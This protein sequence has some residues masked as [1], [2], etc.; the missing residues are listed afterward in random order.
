MILYFLGIM[1]GTFSFSQTVVDE[2]TT[3]NARVNSCN[4]QTQTYG[5]W[6]R[7]RNAPPN[8]V[9][10]NVSKQCMCL[11]KKCFKVGI[12]KDGYT[13][14]TN[15][16]GKLK[17]TPPGIKYKTYATS[18]VEYDNDAIAMGIPQNDAVGKW[19]HKPKNCVRAD[20]Y[21]THGCIAVPCEMWIELKAAMNESAE[22]TVCGGRTGGLHPSQVDNPN[23]STEVEH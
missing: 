21:R 11:G 12:G 23:K 16:F 9:S 4:E 6:W 10:I 22:L 17:K 8:K 2:C 7:P 5:Q 18:K 20:T 1:I 15:G 3:E 13:M 14:T 19:I